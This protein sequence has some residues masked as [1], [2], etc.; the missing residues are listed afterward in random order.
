M[1]LGRNISA[2]KKEIGSKNSI[3]GGKKRKG[4]RLIFEATLQLPLYEGLQLL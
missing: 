2:E 3:I 1:E 4:K